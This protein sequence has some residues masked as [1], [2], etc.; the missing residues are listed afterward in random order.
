[1]TGGRFRRSAGT[2]WLTAALLGLCTLN[3]CSNHG[4]TPNPPPSASKPTTST[5]IPTPTITPPV[6]PKAAPTRK[7]AEAFVRYFW[8]VYNYTYASMDPQALGAISEPD[9]NFCTSSISEVARLHEAGTRIEGTEV[10]VIS[11][12][13]PPVDDVSR[14]IVAAVVAQDAGRSVAK[15]GGTHPITGIKQT[16]S[17]VAVHWK[18][19]SWHIRGV[20][21]DKS[22]KS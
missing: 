16:Q 3:A 12:S 10:R 1:M 19:G 9:C 7:S 13:S 21:I 6:T 20:S 11:L 17:V 15:D 8:D 2:A 22:G 5:P 4:S 18:N 14:L